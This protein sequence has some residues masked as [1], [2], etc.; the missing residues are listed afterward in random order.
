MK[1]QNDELLFLQNILALFMLYFGRAEIWLD[2]L[3]RRDKKMESNYNC[4][5]ACPPVF[6]RKEYK[7]LPN[8]VRNEWWHFVVIYL[9]NFELINLKS[10][11]IELDLETL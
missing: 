3:E 11:N 10:I 8:V 7:E 5:C 9:R 6:W 2:K 1:S 4:H